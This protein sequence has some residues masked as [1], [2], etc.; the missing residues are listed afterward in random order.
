MKRATIVAYAL[1]AIRCQHGMATDVISP[2]SWQYLRQAL[3]A[4]ADLRRASALSDLLARARS[5][6]PPPPA[7]RSTTSLV[8]ILTP[9]FCG[10]QTSKG[11]SQ[12]RHASPASLRDDRRSDTPAGGLPAPLWAMPHAAR[13]RLRGAPCRAEFRRAHRRHPPSGCA[14]GTPGGICR[15][16]ANGLPT[17]RPNPRDFERALLNGRALSASFTPPLIFPVTAAEPIDNTSYIFWHH[18]CLRHGT[19]EKSP[20]LKKRIFK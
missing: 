8:S 2:S 10:V 9:H 12:N 6:M 5:A 19:N 1:P 17:A 4:S 18:S 11:A 16:H 20:H 14:F 7:N 15:D 3:T 13:R